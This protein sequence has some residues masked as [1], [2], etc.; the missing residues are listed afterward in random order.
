MTELKL[1]ARLLIIVATAGL[2]AGLIT[3]L[4]LGWLV[5]PVQVSNVDPTD[6]NAS[7]QEETIVLIAN[8]YALDHDLPRAQTR[9]AQLND[10]KISDRL[11]ALSKKYNSQKNPD[12]VNLARLAVAL[13]N[14]DK[15]IALIA[16]T[17]TPT[18]T[19]TPTETATPTS[20]PPTDT[21]T[22]TPTFTPTIAHT[23]TKTPTRR[24][25]ATATPKPAA[26]APTAW[27]PDYP[28][29]W[30]AGVSVQPANVAPGQQ[31]WHLVKAIYCDITETR[32]GCTNTND[33]WE[34]LPGGPGTI[35]VWVKLIGGKDPLLLDGKVATLEDKS[36]DPQCKC[37][38]TLDFP[39]PTIQVA[40]HPSDKIIGAANAS[41]KIG[42]PNTHVRYFFTFQLV[43]K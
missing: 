41:V 14:N 13:G 4:I 2:V 8:A 17:P 20:V 25:A 42:F 19:I 6:L 38:Y 40:N 30:L 27:Y 16:T 10:P 36:G 23:P 24:P 31:Y 29:G 34:T 7:A 32:F 35:G 43:T 3:G 5:W 18:A 37:T 39:G 15:Q 21:P 28:G 33:G 11:A 1:G 22:A 9:L 12:A 26:I